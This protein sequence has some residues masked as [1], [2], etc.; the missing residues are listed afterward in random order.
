[1]AASLTL[2]SAPASTRALTLA[3][4]PMRHALWIPMGPLLSAFG[5]GGAPP[6]ATTDADARDDWAGRLGVDVETDR[7]L[8]LAAR[9]LGRCFFR[10]A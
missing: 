9:P 2:R 4:F 1:M 8:S 7:D 5:G 6:K 3:R 10:M